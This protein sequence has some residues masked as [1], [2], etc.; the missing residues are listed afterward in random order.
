M[1]IFKTLNLPWNDSKYLQYDSKLLQYFNPR[2]NSFFTTVIYHGQLPRYFYNIGPR[3]KRC[4]RAKRS[5]L[6]CLYIVDE[7][8]KFF[9]T[10]TSDLLTPFASAVCPS[11]RR[12]RIS[13]TSWRFAGHILSPLVHRRSLLPRRPVRISQLPV[14]VARWKHGSHVLQLYLVKN[15]K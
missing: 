4:T 12:K 5:S 7:E 8:K 10:L 6:F 1:V 2:N 13:K 11:E 14:S 9:L 3:L 15:C